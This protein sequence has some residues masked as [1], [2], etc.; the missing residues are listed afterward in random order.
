MVDIDRGKQLTRDCI[1]G[2]VALMHSTLKL[3]S[4]I[5]ANSWIREEASYCLESFGSYLEEEKRRL[6]GYVEQIQNQESLR[7]SIGTLVRE[8]EILMPGGPFGMEDWEQELVIGWCVG[9]LASLE[10]AFRGKLEGE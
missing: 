3:L 4:E 7:R 5:G 1:E 2:V 6:F 9:G 8:G 10:R